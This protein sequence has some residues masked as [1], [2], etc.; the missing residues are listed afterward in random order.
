[1]PGSEEGAEADG[2]F[3]FIS[4]VTG[5][6]ESDK[7]TET[8]E[9][10]SLN[11]TGIRLDGTVFDTSIKKT[12]IDNDVYNEEGSYS[13]LSV[14]YASSWDSILIN[15]STSFVDGFRAGVSLMWWPGQKATVIFTSAHGYG[16]TN[17]SSAIPAYC[18]MIF[19]LELVP[20]ETEE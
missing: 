7:R 11:Y 8:D 2:T 10:L 12:A 14:T 16:S 18:P 1:M 17:K 9:R 15:G 5:L 6:N 13:P 4:N 19:E 3:W 20:N